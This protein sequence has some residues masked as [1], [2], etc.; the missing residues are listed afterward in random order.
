MNIRFHLDW[1]EYHEA[2][3]FLLRDRYPMTPEK[4]IAGLILTASALWF[5]LDSLNLYAVAGL[6]VGLLVLIGAPLIR[7]WNARRKWEREPFYQ[8]EHIVSVSEDGVEYQMGQTKSTLNWLYYQRLLE[9]PTAFLLV[10]GNDSFSLMPKRAFENQEM[11][12]RFRELT[13]KSLHG[14]AK[15]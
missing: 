4:I 11:I 10:Y 3:E 5:F 12:D 14:P 2:R 8:I 6:A 13:T 7:R 15:P 9:S 1:N